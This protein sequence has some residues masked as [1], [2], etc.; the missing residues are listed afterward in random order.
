MVNG[1]EPTSNKEKTTSTVIP[2]F[3][4]TLLLWFRTDIY[5]SFD[6][7]AN[8]ILDLCQNLLRWNAALISPHKNRSFGWFQED[9]LLITHYT[10]LLEMWICAFVF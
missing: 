2:V 5:S 6:Q 7:V 10:P 3:L 1:N 8:F 4:Q 9:I